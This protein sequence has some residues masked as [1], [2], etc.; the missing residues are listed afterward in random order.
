[1]TPL[2][3][4]YISYALLGEALLIVIVLIEMREIQDNQQVFRDLYMPTSEERYPPI[5]QLIEQKDSPEAELFDLLLA[6][7]FPIRKYAEEIDARRMI[8]ISLMEIKKKLKLHQP[9]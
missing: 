7:P 5:R 9:L 4:I 2:L 3:L 1:M 8:D 6:T